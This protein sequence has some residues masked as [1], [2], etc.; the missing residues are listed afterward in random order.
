MATST[1]RIA[2]RFLGLGGRLMVDPAGRLT[3]GLDAC[4]IFSLALTARQQSQ[5]NRIVRAARLLTL[6][7]PAAVI[8]LVR[9]HGTS[10]DGDRWII[11]E[12]C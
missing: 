8:E 11:W 9:Q 4:V 2:Q 1:I 5:G 10:I 6:D 7:R 3:F 12:D